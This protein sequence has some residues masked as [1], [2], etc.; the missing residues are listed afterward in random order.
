[1]TAPQDQPQTPPYL[2]PEYV[3]AILDRI[4]DYALC[5]D[6]R[7]Y[8]WARR[9]RA[10]NAG[11]DPAAI[12]YMKSV[13]Q[14]KTE[15]AEDAFEGL[16]EFLYKLT[17]NQPL[18]LTDN[19]E[20][21]I[22]DS[23][24]EHLERTGAA[25]AERGVP[26]D[27]MA[28]LASVGMVVSAWRNTL[29]PWHYLFTDAEMSWMSLTATRDIAPHM[30]PATNTP[31]FTAI[32]QVLCDGDRLVLPSVPAHDVLGPAWPSIARRIAAHIR[33]CQKAGYTV[34]A[35]ANW[36]GMAGSRWWGRPD[37]EDHSYAI[38]DHLDLNR[39]R[40]RQLI[41]EP[42]KLPFEMWEKAIEYQ[43]DVQYQR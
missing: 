33:H 6:L 1:V 9:R 11:S 30:N 22:T 15:D 39:Y 35:L 42:W 23:F 38:A 19:D 16:Q 28:P 17:T 4:R 36:G 20:E 21:P 37:W 40:T 18:A 26:D 34:R 7:M 24:R 2:T 14:H 29:E 13:E 8:A 5:S 27:V 25:V 10:E 12:E 41:S 43:K 32:E 3:E 31:D